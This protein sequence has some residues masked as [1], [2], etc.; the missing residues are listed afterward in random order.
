ML[1]IGLLLISDSEYLLN[2]LTLMRYWFNLRIKCFLNYNA[3]KVEIVWIVYVVL[4][5]HSEL[6]F[7]IWKPTKSVLSTWKLQELFNTFSFPTENRYICLLNPNILEAVC[8]CLMSNATWSCS[9]IHS[10]LENKLLRF[11]WR[12]GAF[13]WGKRYRL[14]RYWRDSCPRLRANTK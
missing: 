8:E 9:C 14:F 10:E 6:V 2:L 13:G 3:P 12:M 7:S 4:C 5:L 11:Y 1:H